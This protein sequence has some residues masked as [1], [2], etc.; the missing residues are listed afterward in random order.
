M[1]LDAVLGDRSVTWLGSEREKRRYFKVRLGDNLRDNEYPR[2]VFG[3]PPNVTVRCFPDKLPIGY[4]PDC[5]RHVVA[6][7][8]GKGGNGSRQV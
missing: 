7:V 8:A 2:L 4:E 6:S 3:K 1:V 5:Y